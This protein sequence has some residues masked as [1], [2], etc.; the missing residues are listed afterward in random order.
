MLTAPYTLSVNM[1][2]LSLS[3]AANASAVSLS[4]DHAAYAPTQ[5]NTMPQ[6]TRMLRHVSLLVV[7]PD[8]DAKRYQPEYHAPPPILPAATRN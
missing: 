2:S 8:C 7:L 1:G 6:A 3:C 4:L 5:K